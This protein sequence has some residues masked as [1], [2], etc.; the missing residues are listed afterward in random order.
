MKKALIHIIG[1]FCL[2]FSSL[3]ITSVASAHHSFAIYDFGTQVPFKGT[4]RTLNFRNPHITMTLTHVDDEGQ[5]HIIN[6]VEGAPANMAVR[7]GLKPEMIKVG[8]S[9]TVV[10][11]PMKTDSD[12]YFIRQ[13]IL[14][15][16]EEWKW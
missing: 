9:L 11:S 7:A 14:D 6:F 10:G 1:P 15:S 8:T 13:I 3:A 5:E 4:V 12:K 16:G 2:V